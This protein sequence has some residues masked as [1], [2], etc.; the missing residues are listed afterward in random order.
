MAQTLYFKTESFFYTNVINKIVAG[1]V[2]RYVHTGS[3]KQSNPD[4]LCVIGHQNIRYITGRHF[5]HIPISS[6]SLRPFRIIR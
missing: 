4:T 2:T 6:I 5:T 1:R 3:T